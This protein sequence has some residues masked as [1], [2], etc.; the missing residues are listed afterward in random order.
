MVERGLLGR[1]VET[2]LLSSGEPE[3]RAGP[4]EEAGANVLRQLAGS[5][6]AAL[7][8]ITAAPL[9]DEDYRRLTATEAGPQTRDDR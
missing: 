4:L 1:A 9:S 7:L 5:A 2:P 8:D 6:M 3:G